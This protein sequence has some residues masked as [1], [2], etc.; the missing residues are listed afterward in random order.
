LK[1][2]NEGRASIEANKKYQAMNLDASCF[3]LVSTLTGWV[4]VGFVASV[5]YFHAHI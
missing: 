2:L 4:R 1:A 5:G 3:D